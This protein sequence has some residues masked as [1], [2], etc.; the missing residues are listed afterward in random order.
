[1]NVN[2]DPHPINPIIMG[3]EGKK[4]VI[5]P[6]I[7]LDKESNSDVNFA[8]TK[9]TD[10][11]KYLYGSMLYYKMFDVEIFADKEDTIYVNLSSKTYI[12][13]HNVS[14]QSVAPANP[15]TQ[16][17]VVLLYPFS[18]DDGDCCWKSIEGRENCY[19]LIK[20]QISSYMYDPNKSI[21]LTGSVGLNESL[22]VTEF[23]NYLKNSDIIQDDEFDINMYCNEEGDEGDGQS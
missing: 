4:N 17:Y 6:I 9:L 10:N 21:V 16:Q 23:I 5:S 18:E 12:V 15:D 2:H 14:N 3:K 19:E 13:K 22:T 20:E 11:G 1:M 8:I 7:F